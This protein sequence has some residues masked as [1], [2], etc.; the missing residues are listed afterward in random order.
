M[1][2]VCVC[3]GGGGGGG[4]GEAPLAPPLDPPLYWDRILLVIS[5]WGIKQDEVSLIVIIEEEPN[6]NGILIVVNEVY[7]TKLPVHAMG[8]V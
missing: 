1:C 7:E 4:G 2:P 5:A 6:I 3:V 8:S